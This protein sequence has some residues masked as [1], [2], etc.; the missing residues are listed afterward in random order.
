MGHLEHHVVELVFGLC[1]HLCSQQTCDPIFHTH[2]TGLQLLAVH[3]ID[4]VKA[5]GAEPSG[6]MRD[7]KLHAVVTR[8]AF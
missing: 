7:E 8:S 2:K 5:A 3:S 4:D 6:Q 1:M